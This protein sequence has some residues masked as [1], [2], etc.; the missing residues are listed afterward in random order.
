MARRPREAESELASGVH[1]ALADW[2][3]FYSNT[4]SVERMDS[5]DAKAPTCCRKG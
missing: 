3:G 5:A 4:T 1:L 2:Q